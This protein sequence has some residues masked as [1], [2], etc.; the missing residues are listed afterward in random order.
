MVECWRAP[1]RLVV[2]VF[3]LVNVC[4]ASPAQVPSVRPANPDL[5][6]SGAVSQRTPLI[7]DLSSRQSLA[8]RF[9]P[10]GENVTRVTSEAKCNIADRPTPLLR[11][12]IDSLRL[13]QPPKP[14]QPHEFEPADDQLAA[15]GQPDA[16][17]QRF[18]ATLRAGSLRASLGSQ[19]LLYSSLIH[20][21]RARLGAVAEWRLGELTQIRGFGMQSRAEGGVRRTTGKDDAGYRLT[22]LVVQKSLD[23]GGDQQMGL[24]AAWISGHAQVDGDG[25][26]EGDAWSI[27]G[28]ASGLSERLRVQVEYAGSRSDRDDAAKRP[29]TDANAFKVGAEVRAPVDAAA[30][31]YLG[32]G[33]TEVAGGFASPGNPTLAANRRELRAYAGAELGAWELDL[34]FDRRHDNLARDPSMPAVVHDSWKLSTLRSPSPV[35]EKAYGSVEA[36]SYRF[37]AEYSR[38]RPGPAGWAAD[39]EA[40]TRSSDDLTLEGELDATGWQLGL[41]VKGS[42]GRGPVDATAGGATVL[43]VDFYGDLSGSLPIPIKP[44]LSW[45]RRHADDEEAASDIWRA[46]ANIP[47]VVLRP[48]LAA[49]FDLA[50]QHR[51][52]SDGQPSAFSAGIGLDLVWTLQRPAANRRGLS[53][54]VSGKLSSAAD[55]DGTE[56]PQY[57]L[58]ISLSSEDPLGGW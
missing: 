51:G 6:G 41:R 22:G 10:D 27:A 56:D 50:L 57:G 40:E 25:W 58:M 52:S 37:A 47:S 8:L 17:V 31:W 20:R 33:I 4:M 1:A 11:P 43:G 45:K 18:P 29:A 49:D 55:S 12:G 15:A 53:L 28:E 16:P 24:A 34:S 5:S 7:P 39:G 46:T 9:V 42:V 48:D 19:K 3:A 38:R 44:S 14:P 26:H 23:V 30:A 36:L 13:V 54:T 32:T 21:D 35:A 2:L